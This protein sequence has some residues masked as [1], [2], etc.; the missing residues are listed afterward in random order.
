MC[1]FLFVLALFEVMLYLIEI[2]IFSTYELHKK[3]WL[4]PGVRIFWAL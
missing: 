2:K 4:N 3:N 1:F